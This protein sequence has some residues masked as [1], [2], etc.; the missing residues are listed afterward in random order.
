MHLNGLPLCWRH[1][2]RE[3]LLTHQVGHGD[4][5]PCVFDPGE[6]DGAARKHVEGNL[7]ILAVGF[8]ARLGI[9]KQKLECV[10]CL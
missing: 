4:R 2:F 8:E 5:F 9:K 7:A 6:V 10:F 3:E 1:S